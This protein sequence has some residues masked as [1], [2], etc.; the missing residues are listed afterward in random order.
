MKFNLPKSVCAIV[1]HGKI[2]LKYPYMR[3]GKSK[4]YKTESVCAMPLVKAHKKE[5][6]DKVEA[7]AQKRY[8][9]FWEFDKLGV[10][11][12]SQKPKRVTFKCIA[13]KYM[14]A[15]GIKNVPLR[16]KDCIEAFG[17]RDAESITPNEVQ[18]FM[19]SMLTRRVRRFDMYKDKVVTL[20]RR[21]EPSTINTRLSAISEIYKHA[22]KDY[23]VEKNPAKH[24]KTFPT[25]SKQKHIPYDDF[26]EI[27]AELRRKPDNGG[28]WSDNVADVAMMAYFTGMR[29]NEV[30]GLTWDRVFLNDTIPYVQLNA[31]HT[32]TKKARQVPLM[33]NVVDMLRA[34]GKVRKL[35]DNRVFAIKYLNPTWNRALE[36]CMIKEC[37]DFTIADQAL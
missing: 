10:V 13:E 18:E 12:E 31:E 21:Y 22:Q 25:Q 15:N 36:T 9:E 29:K 28:R 6:R 32:K 35:Q 16:I 8:N 37:T 23:T 19:Q 2:F 1:K 26:K 11:P 27:E 14:H 30:L 3:D 4:K 34:R 20:N 24:V 17:N 33:P 5:V 7:L